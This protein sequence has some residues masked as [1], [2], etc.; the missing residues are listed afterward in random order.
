MNRLKA[1]LVAV[2]LASAA[3]FADSVIPSPD[4]CDYLEN[5]FLRW[6]YNCPPLDSG[7]N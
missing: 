1:T 3:V 5:S 7:A 6:L 4:P 2:A